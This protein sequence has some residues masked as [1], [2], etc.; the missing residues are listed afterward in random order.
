MD[1]FTPVIIFLLVICLA[2]L[3][4]LNRSEGRK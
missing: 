3:I 4:V 1:L 2:L